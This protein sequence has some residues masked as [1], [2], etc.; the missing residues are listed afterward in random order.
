MN[1]RW[2]I[3]ALLVLVFTAAG[4]TLRQRWGEPALWPANVLIRDDAFAQ[5]DAIVLLMGSVVSR[6]YH[7]AKLYH[8]GRAE[9]IIFAHTADD[10]AERY[11]FRMN[12]GDATARLLST[13]NVPPSAIV[14]LQ[15]AAVASTQDEA[16]VIGQYLATRGRPQT[17]IV[18]TDWY[19]SS[20][21]GWV[22]DHLPP[23]VRVSV[24]PA[25]FGENIPSNWYRREEPFL[26]VFNEY[27]K[28]VYYLVR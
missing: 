17:I 12:D 16:Q 14:Y 23:A 28:W 9:V 15:D 10:E 8:Q 18:V 24:S 20:R 13:L 27:L 26:N 7:A 5:A 2:K 4:V 22:F 11:G 3:L 19:H 6:T 1:K 25:F 21:A